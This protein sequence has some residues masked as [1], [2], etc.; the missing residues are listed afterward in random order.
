M[1]ESPYK[2]TLLVARPFI[3][4]RWVIAGFAAALRHEMAFRL[5]VAAIAVLLPVG[6]YLGHT[7]IE[8][9]LL[10]GSLLLILITEL[11]NSALEAAVD[12]IS[13][14][15]HPLAKRAKDMGA[16]A[17]FISLVAAASTWLLIL[18]D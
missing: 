10:V 18:L 8:R 11:V 15:K 5:E 6:L 2:R 1:Q 13:L 3:A 7:G 16:A 4:M 12:R 17:V 9:A 14:E